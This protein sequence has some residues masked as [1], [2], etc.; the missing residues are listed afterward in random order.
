MSPDL[1]QA[2]R[3][4]VESNGSKGWIEGP[5]LWIQN[6]RVPVGTVGG[7]PRRPA[8]LEQIPV[9]VEAEISV[10]QP[11]P[12]TEAAEL[13]QVLDPPMSV[14]PESTQVSNPPSM[15]HS[16]STASNLVA[17]PPE[18]STLPIANGTAQLLDS[19]APIV[20]N[21]EVLRAGAVKP[22]MERFVTAFEDLHTTPT[23]VDSKA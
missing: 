10:A 2:A 8:K 16:G 1:D 13:A 20:A 15:A 3:E 5:C 23:Q 19:E 7:K 17:T 9:R 4:A 6:Q 18:A 21:G 12:A 11:A 14:Q 22:P